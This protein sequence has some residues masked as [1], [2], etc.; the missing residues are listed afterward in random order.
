MG[1]NVVQAEIEVPFTDLGAMAR[2]V[3][4]DI[5]AEFVTALLDARYIG[6]AAVARFE[7]LWAAYC[8]TSHAV[9]VGNGT[10]ALQLVLHALRIGAGDEVIVPA[11]TFI[12]TAAAVVRA[13]ATPVF[14]DVDDDTL[15]LTPETVRIA[16]TSRTR[17]VMAVHLYGNM[18]DLSALAALCEGA[19]LHLIED[20]AQAHGAT[21]EG[22]RAG[23][24][25]TAGCFSFYPGK[26][27]GAFGDAGA[28]TTD[29]PDLADTIR[30]LA[31]HGRANG[32]HY[33]HSYVGGNSR[34]DT[35]Q[36]IALTGK[37]THNDAWTDSRIAMAER[38]RKNLAA[39]PGLRIPEVDSR[40]RHVYHLMIVRVPHR[41]RVQ[42]LLA[43]RGIATGVH[44]PVP[45]HHQPP[46]RRFAARALPVAERAAGELLSLPLFPHMSTDQVDRA[47]EVL[48]DVLQEVTR[49]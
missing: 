10:D 16:L 44:Y 3:W 48:T 40:A 11:N 15:L 35:L 18:P 29:D 33:H 1:R 27:L 8:A 26:N 21:W 19:G 49:S 41:D 24:F 17:A 13:G 31:N 20:A 32:D 12:A 6:G 4:P 23:S 39:T 25:G 43:A 45:C 36:A 38:Y 5:E 47:S 2:Q 42:Q 7:Q 9:G 37:L 30:A 28:V 46:L 14:V 22:R 34:L